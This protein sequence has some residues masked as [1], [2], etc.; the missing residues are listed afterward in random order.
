V[1]GLL[2][3]GWSP[4]FWPWWQ[5]LDQMG[6]GFGPPAIGEQDPDLARAQWFATVVDALRS[7]ARDHPWLVVFDDLQ[8]ADMGTLRLLAHLEPLIRSNRVLLLGTVRQS[9]IGRASLPPGLFRNAH[10]LRLG[11]LDL[12]ELT[13]L[14][15]ALTG[16]PPKAET[17]QALDRV[18]AGNPL[19]AGELVRRLN[20][21]GRLDRL[22]SSDDVPVPP[23]VR[24][25]LDEQLA[26]LSDSCRE[27]LAIAAVVGRTF[28][29]GLLAEV[30]ARSPLEVLVDIEEAMSAGVVA[31]VD[32]AGYAFAHPLFRS[33]MHDET[34]VARRVRLHRRIGDALEADAARGGDVDL[35]AL[36]FH[37]LNAAPGG[38]AGKAV[39]YA[40]RAARAAMAALGY[41]DAV[42]LYARA[43]AASEL[44]PSASDRGPLLLGAGEARAAT[45][46]IGGARAAFV[47]AADHARRAGRSA[48]FAA[49][50]LGLAG[51]GFEVALFD[52]QQ[53]ALLEEALQ[54]LGEDL[55]GLRSRVSARLS[56]ALSLAGQEERRAALSESAVVLAQEAGDPGVLAQALAA[57]CDA[58]AGPADVAQRAADAAEI[59]R[60]GRQRGDPGTELLGRR[61]R[62]MAAL[63]MGDLRSVDAEV[64]AFAQIADRLRQPQ[65]RWYVPLWRAMRAVMCGR[66]ADQ[67]ALSVKAEELGRAAQ[68]VNTDIL[69][70]THRWFAC[71]DVGEYETAVS[72]I[73]ISVPP[74]SYAEWEAQFVP[75]HAL[76]R[77]LTNRP[78]E[79]RAVLD[80]ATDVLH[81]AVPDSEWLTMLAQVADVCFR[82]GGHPL[83]RWLYDVLAPFANLWS[84]DGIGAYA[85]G[86][87]HRQL[88]LLAVLLGRSADAAGHFDAA[89]AGNRRA[90]ADLLVARTL[91]DRGLALDEPDTLRAA[92]DAY[93]AL[94]VTRRVAEIES[95]RRDRVVSA[96]SVVSGGSVVS[97]DSDRAGPEHNQFRREGDVWTV[98]FGGRQ[99][100]VR[101]SKGVRDLA[102]LLARPGQE[103]AA[104]D[105]AAAAG[106]P[107]VG[108]DLGE[109]IDARAR[110]EY[111]ARLSELEA[112]LDDAD[113]TGDI[114][115][116]SR[117]HAERDAPLDELSK[118]YGLAGRPRRSSHPAERARTAVTARIR[119]CI[120]RIEALHSVL[121]RH[122][123]RSVRT[124]TFCSYDPD[125]P[126]RWDL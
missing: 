67:R 115:R 19:F 25:V 64:H 74:G 68:S 53:I 98:R 16:S 14:V 47:A 75:L 72:L 76:H 30:A 100:T 80:Q 103:I 69:L 63:E 46:D 6:V 50:A 34:G 111:K 79:A 123:A 24:A 95:L 52:D 39:D 11:G 62:M 28:G 114:G 48:D 12:D 33:V 13:Q 59:V 49:A 44:D 51:S 37:Y 1:D 119:D 29:L 61:L 83:A 2:G 40:E 77:L 31:T 97:A 56:V 20:R 66:L 7:A 60:I 58:H 94:G 121:G 122:L 124:G 113:A 22:A 17:A 108:G 5:L 120:R 107:P 102:R 106:A 55:P 32:P 89:L 101:D 84:V 41:E 21:E 23:T 91:F 78:D 90:G 18:T 9:D 35:A 112:E 92:L 10:H 117:I 81:A 65:Y 116:S 82:L 109:T 96:D 125:Q 43:L 15:E 105:L 26:Y 99:C 54:L 42:A 70:L 110:A 73:E 71:V 93:R 38:T 85:H 87:V 27:V 36:S 86:P 3:D 118:A 88:G 4:P 8:W 126:T 104:L 57:R 45:G